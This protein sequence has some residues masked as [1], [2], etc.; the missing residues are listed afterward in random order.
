VVG[1]LGAARGQPLPITGPQALSFAE[2]TAEIAAAIGR[3]L[4]Y[5]PISEDEGT[6]TLD[7]PR[8]GPVLG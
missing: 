6:T 7:R 4:S 3:P 5:Q 1:A 2:M 8:R